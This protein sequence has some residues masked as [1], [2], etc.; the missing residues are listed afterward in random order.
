MRPKTFLTGE[1]DIDHSQIDADALSVI[2]QLREAG[3]AAYLVGG[4][5]RDLLV[6]KT[7]KDFDISTS[8]QPEE[9]KALF[10]R[11]CLLIGKRFRLAHVRFGHKVIEVATFRSGDNESDLIIR[12]NTWGSPEED[13]LRRDFTINGL[14]YDPLE[15]T[16]IDYVGGWEDIHKGLLRTIGDPVIRFKQDPVRMIRLL[17]FRARFGFEIEAETKKALLGCREEIIKSSPARI[18]EEFFRMLE[19]GASASF[20]H[21]MIQA[22]MLHL[23]FPT[24]TEYL[25]SNLGSSIYELLEAADQI[26][27]SNKQATLDRAILS[28][29]L[30]YPI[31]ESELRLKFQNTGNVPHLG[32]VMIVASDLIRTMVT[33]SFSHFPRKISSGMSY[34]MSMQSRLT[35]ISGRKRNPPKFIRHK[36]FPLALQFLKLRSIRNKEI[37]DVYATW[38]NFYRQ[39]T[40]TGAHKERHHHHS[41]E[42]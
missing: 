7:P 34:I 18:L 26:H 31:L 42:S 12:D 28:S 25:T 24:L 13:A 30:L 38:K 10:K 17:K 35:P 1:H 27:L 40:R 8:A 20:L 15:H 23:L 3:Y 11:N 33:T 2:H 36:E 19:S 41:K 6:K 5:V 22:K 16:I 4:S 32:E 39:Q 29:C 14:F 9:I 21:L 37:M